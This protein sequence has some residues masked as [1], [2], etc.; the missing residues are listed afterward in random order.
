MDVLVLTISDRASAGVYEDTSG[1]ALE[2]M[3]RNAFDP[4]SVYRKIVP[5]ESEPILGAYEEFNTCNFIITTGG[6]GIS[7]RD[8]TPDVTTIFC[9]RMIPGIAEMLRAESLK[10][11]QNAVFSRSVAGI[12][13]STIIINLPGSLR[14]ATYCLEQLIPLLPHALRMLRGEGHEK[15]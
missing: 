5:D 11:T 2:K 6:T 4:I 10:Q 15:G 13:N 3:L 7:P 9:D 14:G 8:I 1:P 12:K